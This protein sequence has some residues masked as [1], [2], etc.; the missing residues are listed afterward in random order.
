MGLDISIALERAILLRRIFRLALAASPLRLLKLF[1]FSLK[2][3][4]RV[5]THNRLRMSPF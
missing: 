1:S 5:G 3:K 4:F 2:E